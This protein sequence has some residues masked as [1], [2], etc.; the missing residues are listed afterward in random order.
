MAGF[1]ALETLGD[2]ERRR[3]LAVATRR[4][5]AR[6]EVLFHQ[7]DP[8][9][10]FHLIDRGHVKISTL[11]PTGE[12]ATLAILVPGESFGEQA[13]L[14]PDLVR[15]ATATALDATQTLT[16]KTDDF[17]DLRTRHPQVND[18]L[19]QVL[20]EQV[21]RLSEQIAEARFVPADQRI[22][23]YLE[24]LAGIYGDGSGAPVEIPLSQD[25]VAQ[26]AGTTR[27]TV[28]RF[29]Q[30]LGDAVSLG[31]GRITVA[32]LDAVTARA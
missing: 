6:N 5:F 21:R 2:D 11:S 15:T 13:L 10:T 16:L 8:G 29:L 14:Q 17:H 25:E 23:R 22:A 4:K 19:V 9:N 18:F 20:A 30:S 1:A 32:D 26:L 31:R 24:R 27:P 3:V 7:G 28:N 12:S